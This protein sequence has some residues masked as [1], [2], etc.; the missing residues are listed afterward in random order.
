LRVFLK[1]LA[2]RDIKYL[3]LYND[4][5][6]IEFLDTVKKRVTGLSRDAV[7]AILDSPNQ[8]TTSGQRDVTFMMMLYGTAARINELLELKISALFLDAPKPHATIIGKGNVIRTLYLLPQAA[9]YLRSYLRVFHG[10]N[11][12]PDNYLFFSRNKGKNSKLSQPAI[13]KMLKKH[14]VIA[15]KTCSDVPLDLHAHQFR[16]A[17]ASHW[18]EDG[19]NIVQISFLLGHAHLETT[20]VYLDITTEEEAKAMATLQDENDTKVSKKW[21]TGSGDLSSFCGVKP[22]ASR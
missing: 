22:I 18:L 5:T 9:A 10:E 2:S 13:A 17:K 21:K 4:A 14:A 20:M 3:Y 7:K 11:P 15:H 16:H 12:N 8:H 1:Y 6:K 19:M